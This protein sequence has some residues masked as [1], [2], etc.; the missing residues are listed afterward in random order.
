MLDGH[1]SRVDATSVGLAAERLVKGLFKVRVLALLSSTAHKQAIATVISRSAVGADG[2]LAGVVVFVSYAVFL[3]VNFSGYIDVVLAIAGLMGFTLPENFA[4]PFAADSFIDFWNRWHITLSTWLKEYV[5]MPMLTSL[6]R[7]YPEKAVAPY[8]GIVAYFV[9]FFLVGVWHGQNSTFAF[10]GVLQGLG[11]AVNKLFQVLAAKRLGRAGFRKLS[12]NPLWCAVG[13]GLTFTWF[14]FSLTWF[15]S[16]WASIRA[17]YSSLSTVQIV[18]CWSGVF[19]AATIVLSTWE[20]V[21]ALVAPE[22]SPVN[23]L[24]VSRYPRTAWT[25]VLVIVVAAMGILLDQPV[26][27]IVYGKF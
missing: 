15:W 16:D 19:V 17:I 22:A 4:N 1:G 11:V 14:T 20:A 2:A 12:D 10:F 24:L 5:Y 8:L 21:R 25:T 3:Y 26:P 6:M 9:T 23:R 7:R 18:L 27:E 13:R